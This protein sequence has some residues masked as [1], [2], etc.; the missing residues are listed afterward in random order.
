MRT[1]A[2]QAVRDVEAAAAWIA[3]N[4]GGPDVA[5]RMV[6]AVLEA[7]DRIAGRPELGRLQLDLVPAPFRF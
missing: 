4:A 3:D 2:P 6:Q 1:F 5:R 7:A